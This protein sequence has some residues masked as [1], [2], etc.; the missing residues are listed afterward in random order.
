MFFFDYLWCG[1]WLGTISSKNNFQG[2]PQMKAILTTITVF[3]ASTVL[4]AQGSGGTDCWQATI[5]GTD[6]GC[7]TTACDGT[8]SGCSR[9]EFTAR[10]TGTYDWDV[11]TTCVPGDCGSCNTCAY[12]YENGQQILGGNCHTNNCQGGDCNTSCQVQL[13]ADHNYTLYVCLYHC[14]D[15]EDCANCGQ[16]CTAHACLRYSTTATCY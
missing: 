13:T 9:L 4:W 12:I 8:R 1:L 16:S 2:R 6:T 7:S 5:N 10:C 14:P 11:W 15:E 3:V